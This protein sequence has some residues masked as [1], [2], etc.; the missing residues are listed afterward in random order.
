MATKLGKIK[1]ISD[2][3]SVWA[4]EANDFTKWLAEEDNLAEL[5]D[6]IGIE[7]EL[8]ETES[9]VGDFNVDLFAT[10]SGTGRKSSLKTNLNIQTMTTLGNLSPT[11]QEKELR[12]LFGL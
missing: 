1:K 3:R 9:S 10:E 6:S 8:E 7:I 2:L 12:L 5:S 11:H 4:H